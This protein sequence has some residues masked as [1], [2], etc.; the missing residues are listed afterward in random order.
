MI[1]EDYML[2]GD[3]QKLLCLS[4]D[5][6]IRLELSH[7]HKPFEKGEWARVVEVELKNIQDLLFEN[8]DTF[9]ID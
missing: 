6:L 7:P 8:D 9:L 2:G 5:C 1:Q 3:S 4:S